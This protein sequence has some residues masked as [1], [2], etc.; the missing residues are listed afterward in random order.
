MDTTTRF[1]LT[2]L[3]TYV[4]LFV[5]TMWT[6]LAA[7]PRLS[8]RLIL[9][10]LDIFESTMLMVVWEYQGDN[11]LKFLF[12]HH[13]IQSGTAVVCAHPATALQHRGKSQSTQTDDSLDAVLARQQIQALDKL[14]NGL[15]PGLL[16]AL[17]EL[18]QRG[19]LD[20]QLVNQ[21]CEQNLS[22]PLISTE[23]EL[24]PQSVCS[25]G[26]LDAIEAGLQILVDKI[27]IV[28]TRLSQLQHAISEAPL[29]IIASRTGEH[30][31]RLASV[32]DSLN[33]VKAKC[34]I[35]RMLALQLVQ[36]LAALDTT[37]ASI[38]LSPCETARQVAD[39]IVQTDDPAQDV[40]RNNSVFTELAETQVATP[41]H[42]G[43]EQP[44]MLYSSSS[45]IST[46]DA[47]AA[48]ED[49]AGDAEASTSDSDQCSVRSLKSLQMYA[50]SEKM[51]SLVGTSDIMA[52]NITR[53]LPFT[54]Q[55]VVPIE[56][57]KS[58][59]P[60]PIKIYKQYRFSIRR[61]IKRYSWFG[62]KAQHSQAQE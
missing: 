26:E 11:I 14:V 35:D 49:S 59:A 19:A 45:S 17:S 28:D 8:V 15:M 47:A 37:L 30:D 52:V 9:R 22:L 48:D 12:K 2:G 23:P 16:C 43:T 25:S 32:V 5:L 7:I 1:S 46:D 56:S 18:P 54:A 39:A 10:V 55:P 6:W 20:C 51:T 42:T 38:D 4:V 40:S 27:G 34:E 57:G 31:D 60:P 21:A 13:Y 24:Q 36:S 58:E 44:E 3:L 53:D 41:I 50:N 29:A 62:K 33:A 61:G